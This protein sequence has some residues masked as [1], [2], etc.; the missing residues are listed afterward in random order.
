M[1][2]YTKQHKHYCGNDLH[3]NKMYL[4]IL[5][6]VGEIVLHRNMKT[7]RQSFLAAIDPLVFVSCKASIQ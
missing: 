3:A 1:R 7:T 4:C 6:D 2:F 5:N